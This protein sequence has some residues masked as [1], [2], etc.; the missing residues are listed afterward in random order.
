MLARVELALDRANRRPVHKLAGPRIAI[1][2]KY[3]AL[4][5]N[6]DR[7]CPSLWLR[8]KERWT[9]P[10]RRFV[11]APWTISLFRSKR[12]KCPPQWRGQLPSQPRNPPHRPTANQNCDRKT[13]FD[14]AAMVAASPSM[15]QLVRSCS[16]LASSCLPILVIG[17]TGVGKQQIIR[18]IHSL[19]RGRDEPFVA[20]NC[21]AMQE[22]QLV[23]MFFGREGSDCENTST[24]TGLIERAAGGTLLLRNVTGLP[25]W[26]QKEFLQAAQAGSFSRP[27]RSDS[28][29]FRA[30]VSASTAYLP[31]DSI[32]QGTLLQDLYGYLGA[33]PL[34]IP[35]LRHRHEDIRPFVEGLSVK[36]CAELSPGNVR[37]FSEEALVLLETYDWP[38]NIHELSNFIRRLFVFV[39]ERDVTA[40]HVREHLTSPPTPRDVNTITV[41]FVGDLKLIEG[42]IVAEAIN[43]AQGNKSA[44][45]RSLGL[46]RKTLYRIIENHANGRAKNGTC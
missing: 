24:R 40:A 29:P 41:P 28:I 23:E 33:C 3:S 20:V 43:R 4:L 27:G 32:K 45:A 16:N 8:R 22:S 18:L 34:N 39:S 14:A 46:H 12:Y 13:E 42:A 44:A 37:R 9:R 21:D 15:K 26:M 35:P 19:G 30:R 1:H 38:G 6:D 5:G 31:A 25:R 2:W 17:E 36:I 11:S 7:N 10:S